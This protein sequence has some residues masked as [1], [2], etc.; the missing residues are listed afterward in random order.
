MAHQQWNWGVREEMPC[1]TAKKALSQSTM[2]VSAHHDQRSLMVS[3]RGNQ[4]R[5]GAMLVFR[6][7]YRV[8]SNVVPGKIF[9][10][11]GRI[12]TVNLILGRGEDRHPG[13]EM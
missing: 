10:Q 11:I 4:G 6:N 8:R 3:C 7:D 12:D 5:A 1:H 2:G 13:G 9:R